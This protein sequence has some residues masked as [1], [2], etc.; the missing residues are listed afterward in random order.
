MLEEES[1]RL[2]YGTYRLFPMELWLGNV[3]NTMA[4]RATINLW[5]ATA[6][7]NGIQHRNLRTMKVKYRVA[8]L[9]EIK[10]GETRNGWCIW[11]K[12]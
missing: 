10:S 4:I 7:R 8:K 6:H 12:I 9:G 2:E 3:N 1:Q 5:L 11:V